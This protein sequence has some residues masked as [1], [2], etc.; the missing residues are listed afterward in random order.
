M[1]RV[2]V[3]AAALAMIAGCAQE[4]QSVENTSNQSPSTPTGTIVGRVTSLRTG[5]PLAGVTVTVPSS[6]G[7]RSATTESDGTYSLGG[8][9]GGATYAA[10]F[11]LASHVTALRAAVIPNTAGDFP[12]NGIAQVD[13]ALAEANATVTGHVYARDGAP[14]AG[15]VLTVDLRADG[16]DLVKSAT[17]DGQGAYTLS[18]L[19][20]APAGVAVAVVA[21]PWD[22]N[23]DGLA[24]YDALART[25]AAY[26]AATSLLDFDL[27]LAAAD[28]L[29]LATSVDSGSCAPT[30][31][32]QLTFNREL[33]VALT[34]VT[35][36]DAT[37]SKFVAIT[38][39]P[40]GTGKILTIAPA[41]G[42]ALSAYHSYVI[43]VDG[44]ATNGATLATSRSFSVDVAVALLPPVA[45]LVVNPA[46][47]D[48]DTKT[49]TLGWTAS[50]AASGYQV[51]VRDTAGNPSWL[52]VATPANSF[53]PT[54][55]VTLPAAFDLYAFDGVQTPLAGGVGVDFAVVAVNAT[56][57]APSPTTATPVRRADTVGP[58]VQSAP[59]LGNADNSAGGTAR[60]ITLTLNFSEYMDPAAIPTIGLPGAGET[61][62]FAWS[63]TSRKVGV[64]TITVLAG[65]DGRGRYL[66][67]GA[68]DSS[69]N[70]MTPWSATLTGTVQLIANG[71]FETGDPT[72]WA[73]TYSGTATAPFATTSAASTGS[74]SARLGNTTAVSQSGTSALYQLVTL[75]AGYASIV[76]SVSYR[77]YTNYPYAGW[78]TSSC[79][80][81]NSAGTAT[82]YTLFT[83][84]EDLTYFKTASLNITSLAGTTIRLTCQTVQ[85]GL[86]VTGMYLDDVSIVASP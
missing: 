6:G 85:K 68:K 30:A 47:A 18:G 5:L 48:Y 66:V 32:I 11:S 13:V 20:G 40:D 53:T 45:D 31:P 69:G 25:A 22:A 24:D 2:V 21:Q 37:A 50:P 81:Q 72:G 67:T 59:L 19:P 52:L 17:S 75:P 62:T 28:L 83:T 55:S 79:L 74:W 86:D 23:A 36:Y 29:L 78:D 80:V 77:P 70:A 54:A 9:L 3:A 64:F 16:F 49:Y 26:P 43:A 34:A 46:R 10:R 63:G 38:T 1:N 60:T 33:D 14:A 71:G 84:Y 73:T 57:D 41:G 56:G 35:L 61:A 76:A 7:A 44:V 4:K 8:L 12:S 58:V 51:W 39:A 82:Y 15:V 65:T 42:A 27:R